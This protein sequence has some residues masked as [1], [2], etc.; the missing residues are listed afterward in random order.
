MIRNSSNTTAIVANNGE[1][2]QLFTIPRYDNQTIF[3][4]VNQ[5]EQGSLFYNRLTDT[6]YYVG[7]SGG[8]NYYRELA[9]SSLPPTSNWLNNTDPVYGAYIYTSI[10]NSSVVIN[11]TTIDSGAKL[12]VHGGIHSTSQ[13]S[14][15]GGIDVSNGEIYFLGNALVNMIATG[16]GN[17]SS[18]YTIST[19]NNF[20][21]AV[22]NTT[23]LSATTS[24]LI[25]SN[26]TTL[27]AT[28]GIFN[29]LTANGISLSGVNSKLLFN[30]DPTKYIGLDTGNNA[31]IIGNAGNNNSIELETRHVSIGTNNAYDADVCLNIQGK[32]N[33]S[34]NIQVK[35]QHDDVNS[36]LGYLMTPDN[37]FNIAS[38]NQS[39]LQMG[40]LTGGDSGTFVPM[41]ELSPNSG[42]V[43]ISGTLSVNNV[44]IQDFGDE[45]QLT[46][47][48][49]LEPK[50]GTG[51]Q[52]LIGAKFGDPN[53]LNTDAMLAIKSTNVSDLAIDTNGDVWI[54]SDKT[55]GIH[56]H[57]SNV[58][59]SSGIIAEIAG[60][61]NT[62]SALAPLIVRNPH[63]ANLEPIR[64]SNSSS[65]T[66][67]NYIEFYN[68][69][70]NNLIIGNQ[71]STL[72]EVKNSG[73]L[74]MSNGV[75]GNGNVVA[76][77]NNV[78]LYLQ[79]SQ[80]WDGVS[81]LNT[82]ESDNNVVIIKG[83]HVP[84][85]N[86]IRMGTQSNGEAYYDIECPNT[87][88]L[89]FQRTQLTTATTIM[90]ITPT[91][92]YANNP[93]GNGY[94]FGSTTSYG[95]EQPVGTNNIVL[96]ATSVGNVEVNL[97]NSSGYLNVKG[98][99][100]DQA[101]LFEGKNSNSNRQYAK[102]QS[103]NGT[104]QGYVGS[105]DG[106]G[107]WLGAYN[108]NVYI[109]VPAGKFTYIDRPLAD[110]FYYNKKEDPAVIRESC[111]ITP[112]VFVYNGST[113][114]FGNTPTIQSVVRN[115]IG[116]Y[117]IT[118]KMNST[119]SYVACIGARD[120]PATA[121][122]CCDVPTTTS[123][124]VYCYDNNGNLQDVRT[125][126]IRFVYDNGV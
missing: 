122:T 73:D 111:I 68:T 51:I 18:N 53:P 36:G 37:N 25:T 115:S 65:G 16:S 60:Y 1:F 9:S 102:F 26:I 50:G 17:F 70:A 83:I 10:P 114:D 109:D 4:N 95:L 82:I 75:Y 62:T 74:F 31:I 66:T 96:K 77:Y 71:T 2:D 90:D 113:T 45:W 104:G 106:L 43:N 61:N 33:N 124:N 86:Q 98:F 89:R 101:M 92:I 32:K 103:Q 49:Y 54:N 39:K 67:S 28:S 120:S 13:I 46:G 64:F 58:W 30:N 85:G 12:H 59:Q 55:T 15:E 41:V 22:L 121:F 81:T 112:V 19:P 7:A 99:S 11:G 78:P 5:V 126:V 110:D 88:T 47:S 44:P 125:S 63:I 123:V 35:L 6:C 40:Y 42:I 91:G 97:G 117:T 107:M 8:T 56:L 3:P 24:T 52:V 105:A 116:Y 87:N 108:D 100:N 118:Y 21:T 27:N 84:F 94:Y 29:S 57:K 38:N 69:V 80:A 76:H 93:N 34:N 14:A 20:Q 79:K 23:T 72:A 48:T 119:G